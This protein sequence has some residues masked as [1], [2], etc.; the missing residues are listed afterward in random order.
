MERRMSI[1]K[2]VEPIL[3]SAIKLIYQV[4]D[5]KNMPRAAAP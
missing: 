2:K 1:L 3:E 5:V 4:I